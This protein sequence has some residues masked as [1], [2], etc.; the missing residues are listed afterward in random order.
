MEP[1]HLRSI[2]L[3]RRIFRRHNGTMRTREALCA[4]IHPRTLYAMRDQGVITPVARGLYRLA[5]LPP[6]ASPDLVPVA[7]KVPNG[8]I[9]LISALAFHEITTQIPHEVCVAL[10]RGARPPRIKHPP[11]RVFWFAG[12]AFTEGQETHR[13]DDVPVRIYS[14]EKTV[15]D[16]FRYRDVVGLDVAIEALRLLLKRGRPDLDSLVRFARVSR[17]EKIMRPYL[18]ALLG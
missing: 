13:V 12:M 3:A 8:V 15:A 4:G 5:D 1:S 2:E 10:A 6:L 14:R 11:I 7:M 9:C 17:V 18:E 16:C